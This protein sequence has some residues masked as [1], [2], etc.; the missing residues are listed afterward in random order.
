[1]PLTVTLSSS[2]QTTDG[3]LTSQLIGYQGEHYNGQFPAFINLFIASE[4]TVALEFPGWYR[5]NWRDDYKTYLVLLSVGLTLQ[6]TKDELR[7]QRMMLAIAGISVILVSIPNLVL[8]LNEWKVPEVNALFVGDW[9]I[10]EDYDPV[11]I[12]LRACGKC[13]SKPLTSNLCRIPKT[14]R[15]LLERRLSLRLNPNPSHIEQQKKILEAAQ[16][17]ASVKECRR[18]LREYNISLASLLSEDWTH[19]YSRR[20]M[21]IITHVTKSIIPTGEA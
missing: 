15:E 6:P 17:R 2:T 7:R 13:A 10:K 16:R 1:M 20:E 21:E 5:K 3:P 9:H 19:T 8:I 12:G 18:D 4:R 11:L 14:T